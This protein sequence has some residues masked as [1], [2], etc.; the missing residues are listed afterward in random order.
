MSGPAPFAPRRLLVALDA[1]APS[2]AALEAAVA[3]ARRFGAEVVGLFVRDALWAHLA[4]HPAARHVDAA[5]GG[6]RPADPDAMA[7]A[8]GAL[9]RS[10]RRR[11]EALAQR[12]AVRA[13]FHEVQGQ[14]SAEVVALATSCDLV[15]A[16]R[17]GWRG[18]SAGRLGST[19]LA[20]LASERTSVLLLSAGQSPERPVALVLAPG[21]DS[22]RA[23]SAAL[24]LAS[25][26]GG[27]LSLLL[28][29]EAGAERDR[30][31]QEALT[32]ARERGLVVSVTAVD[33][34]SGPAIARALQGR[35][36]RTLVL[37]ADL[38]H[39]P[40]QARDLLGSV[41]CPVL[42]VR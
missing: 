15:C 30:L 27:R 36:C 23:L 8:A 20:L 1:S 26:D 11:L 16:G 13:T 3:W 39:G 34:L 22:R 40:A 38:L 7:E 19:A 24:A 21:A 33:G 17:T 41:A 12:S 14:V 4:A 28:A 10:V 6:A 2:Q 9:G 42:A 31:E 25:D 29:G 37:P 32:G 5:S 35:P 18:G